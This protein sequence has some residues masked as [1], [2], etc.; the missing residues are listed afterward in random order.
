MFSFFKKIASPFTKL[1]SALGQ[2]IRTLF[3]TQESDETYEEL[4]RLLY[5]ADLGAELAL[6]LVTEVRSWKRTHKDAPA[7]AVLGFVRTK[8]LSLL[9]AAPPKTTLHSPH[10]ILMVGVNGSGKTTSTAKLAK[11]YHSQGKQVLIAAADTFRAAAVEQLEK[12][13]NQLGV[14]LIKAQPKSDPAAVAFDALQAAISRKADILLIDT[15]G[16]LQ[17][18]TDLMHE[19]SKIRRVLQKLL[20]NAP[21]ETLLVLDATLGQ[22]A[23]SQATTFH[24]FTPLTGLI[25]TKLDGSAK[26]GIAISIHKQLHLPI[27]WTGL[28]EGE[29]DFVPFNP[30]E[31]IDG[32]LSE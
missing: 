11:H 29:D 1:K 15:A 21:H 9:P 30:E 25:L 18:K 7:E 8:L 28:G 23:L 13:A 5:E 14:D 20:P 31:Y 10:V 32:L 2:K 26:G 3:S 19:L 4:E 22:N 16:R 6:S 27:L 24:Q 17:N 12:W